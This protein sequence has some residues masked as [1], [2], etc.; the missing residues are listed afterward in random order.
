MA[1][2]KMDGHVLT[3]YTDLYCQNQNRHCNRPVETGEKLET[4]DFRAQVQ[5]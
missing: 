3:K 1:E 2:S 5:C 4:L